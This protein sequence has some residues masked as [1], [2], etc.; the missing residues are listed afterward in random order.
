[1]SLLL[2]VNAY[3]FYRVNWKFLGYLNALFPRDLFAPIVSWVL[4]GCIAC[5]ASSLSFN[6]P[7]NL[8]DGAYVYKSWTKNVQV[9]WASGDMP[10]DN[11]LPFFAGEFLIRDVNLQEVHPFAPGQEIVLRTSNKKYYK[12]FDIPDLKRINIKLEESEI[13]WKYQNNTVI[14]SYDKPP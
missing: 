2:G 10:A 14:I 4:L 6:S 13:A 3:I 7:G 11:A 12:R 1:L 9:Q 8:P 5:A